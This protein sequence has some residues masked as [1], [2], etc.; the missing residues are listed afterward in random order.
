MGRESQIEMDRYTEVQ[1]GQKT[2]HYVPHLNQ[3]N[4][5][6]LICRYSELFQYMYF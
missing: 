4:F 5:F 2:F 3:Q 6:L 1:E